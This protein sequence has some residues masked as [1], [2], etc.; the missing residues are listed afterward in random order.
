MPTKILLQ[1]RR[2]NPRIELPRTPKARTVDRALLA[3]VR[4][5]R[6]QSNCGVK[7]TPRYR[8]QEARFMV[9]NELPFDKVIDATWA[10]WCGE[11]H[12]L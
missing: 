5:W 12:F 1:E 2:G 10:P 11:R 9:K 3:K 4:T 7:K 6:D 8:I